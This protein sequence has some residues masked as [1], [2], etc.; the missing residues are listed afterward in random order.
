MNDAC[1]LYAAL[2][3]SLLVH[4]LCTWPTLISWSHCPMVC[5]EKMGKKRR[6]NLAKPTHPNFLVTLSHGLCREEGRPQKSCLRC[7]PTPAIVQAMSLSSSGGGSQK[8]RPQLR[9]SGAEPPPPRDRSNSK[10]SSHSSR[11]RS[12]GMSRGDTSTQRTFTV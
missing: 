2:F 3:I 10:Q 9:S 6:P 11:T 4:S 8:Q 12:P 1:M 7:L 5:A